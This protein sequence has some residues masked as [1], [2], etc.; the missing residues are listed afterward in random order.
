MPYDNPHYLLLNIAMGGNLGGYIPDSFTEDYMDIDYIR[1]FQEGDQ[2][3][4]SKNLN[5]NKKITLFPNP[6]NKSFTIQSEIYINT[7]LIYDFTGQLLMSVPVNQNKKTIDFNL[8]KGTYY[9]K[10][11]SKNG[12]SFKS[13]LVN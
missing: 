7:I 5:Q 11:I 8:S 9:V 4:N 13:F 3:A 1:V 10:I 2:T 12:I 6:A